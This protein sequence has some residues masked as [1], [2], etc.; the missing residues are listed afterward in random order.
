VRRDDP[1]LCAAKTPKTETR[2][3]QTRRYERREHRRWTRYGH[4]AHARFRCCSNEFRA[5]ITHDRRTSIR[6]ERDV[7]TS[8]E[9]RNDARDIACRSVRVE[10]FDGF[11]QAE[12][13]EEPARATRVFCRDTRHARKRFDGTCAEITQVANGCGHRVEHTL[14]DFS[15][16]TSALDADSIAEFFFEILAQLRR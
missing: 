13:R 4:D 2:P 3:G 9:M 14:C 8:N 11:A 15:V 5:W 10:T 16:H 6:H 7:F 12:V 1:C